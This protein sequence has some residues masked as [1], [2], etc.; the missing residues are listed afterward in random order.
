MTKTIPE[1][2]WAAELHR[3]TSRNSGRVTKLEVDSPDY[4]AKREAGFPLRGIA[5]DSAD[6]RV[7]ITLG[8]QANG[9]LNLTHSIKDAQ[10]IFVL[11]DARG[12]DEA[13]AIAHKDSQT[14]LRF[15]D[16]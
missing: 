4:C 11:V 12:R 3:F 10:A 15:L 1:N 13:L 8:D 16:L 14:L 7:L 6:Q 9:D 2:S 5:Y